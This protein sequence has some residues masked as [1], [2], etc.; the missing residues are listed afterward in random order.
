[1]FDVSCIDLIARS[2]DFENPITMKE[3]QEAIQ[4]LNRGK[5]ADKYNIKAE[6]LQNMMQTIS[7][8]LLQLFEKCRQS[9]YVR[10]EFKSGI[11]TSIPKRGKSAAELDNHR[12]ITVVS[13][14]GKVFEHVISE[15]YKPTQNINQSYNGNT[16]V[17]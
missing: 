16:S 7:P 8:I 14:L 17:E 4:K 5:S 11:L 15:R 6:V 2:N 13:L 1:M 9:Q 10:A 3:V 12:G